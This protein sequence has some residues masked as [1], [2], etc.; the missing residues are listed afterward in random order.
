MPKT[1]KQPTTLT[2][3][4]WFRELCKT[5]EKLAR[6]A[7]DAG[8]EPN[9]HEPGVT[10]TIF[11]RTL[12]NAMGDFL[13]P[14]PPQIEQVVVLDDGNREC[15]VN[16]ATVLA[17]ATSVASLVEC[18]EHPVHCEVCRF[19]EKHSLCRQGTCGWAAERD[20]REANPQRDPTT[21]ADDFCLRGE[22]EGA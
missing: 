19:W 14:R 7:K 21:N 20:G 10:A 12:D 18:M 17:L 9:W 3:Q 13:A 8:V 11:G 16:L 22:R 2:E 15:I 6:F 4:N 1:K 5:S